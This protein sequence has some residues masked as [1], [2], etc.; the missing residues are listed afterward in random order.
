MPENTT[1]TKQIAPTL[2]VIHTLTHKVAQISLN[3]SIWRCR[4]NLGES[5]NG[6]VCW[7]SY[8]RSQSTYGNVLSS[9]H[10]VTLRK[11]V[12]LRWC[13]IINV[14]VLDARRMR[15][16][17]VQWCHSEECP[18]QLGTDSCCANDEIGDD[19]KRNVQRARW[20]IWWNHTTMCSRMTTRSHN[21]DAFTQRR[22]VHTT[23]TCSH[24]DDGFPQKTRKAREG[25][26]FTRR[27]SVHEKAIG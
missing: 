5:I 17:L 13:G 2:L 4:V 23:T 9:T 3:W 19:T 6:G 26:R 1:H 20:F 24:K 14:K 15:T 21:D 7:R 27:Q 22:R 11:R 8:S 16:L 12:M 25:N 10:E 18:T